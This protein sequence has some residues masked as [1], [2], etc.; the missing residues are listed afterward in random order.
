MVGKQGHRETI[1]D[2][3]A[4]MIAADSRSSPANGVASWAAR[5]SAK[6]VQ[7]CLRI[8]LVLR[9]LVLL[10]LV[11]GL[12][13]AACSNV[14]SGE[15]LIGI[16]ASTD[17]ALGDDRL[18]FA[19]HEIGGTRRGSPD[20]VVEVVASPLDDPTTQLTATATF[21]PI[22]P[23][24]VG[25]YVV[26]LPFSRAGT[27]QIEFSISTGEPTDLFL[28]EIQETPRSLAVGEAAPVLVTPTLGDTAIED[29][30]TDSDPLDSMYEVSLD[31][32][33]TNGNKTVVIFATPAYCTS[34][35]CGPMLDQTKAMVEDFPDVNFLHIEVY[36]GFRETGFAPD[37]QHLAPS[38]LA[39]RLQ[40]EPWV[41]V[42]DEWGVVIGRLDGV[43]AE[44][45]IESL[46]GR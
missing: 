10:L 8:L 23:G 22:I 24:S 15:R 26:A 36:E 6:L 20:E 32:A 29:L 14:D 2:D 9:K 18:L 1:P 40:S 37:E 45:E 41:F 30:T 39:F 5:T 42:M 34:A 28:V 21:A 12:V 7:S 46:L 11:L 17:S 33:L 4:L 25:L 38:V 3:R 13:G 19:V 31:S 27:W 44:G 16:R 43:L 35:A